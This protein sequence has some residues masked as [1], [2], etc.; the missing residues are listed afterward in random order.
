MH[1]ESI[2]KHVGRERRSL[3]YLHAVQGVLGEKRSKTRLQGDLARKEDTQ[4]SARLPPNQSTA[5]QSPQSKHALPPAPGDVTSAG[6]S[7]SSS[8]EDGLKQQGQSNQWA[9]GDWKEE[10][11]LLASR[12]CK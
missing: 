6:L 4:P 10:T 9:S 2:T 3:K 8:P 1:G 11:T 12:L 7:L 5:G